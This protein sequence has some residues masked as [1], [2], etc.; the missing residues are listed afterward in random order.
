[1]KTPNNLIKQHVDYESPK[2]MELYSNEASSSLK[3][4]EVALSKINHHDQSTLLLSYP[5]PDNAND[6]GRK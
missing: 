5:A 1:M 2:E 3:F 4:S 6:P